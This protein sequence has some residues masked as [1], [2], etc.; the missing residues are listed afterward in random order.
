MQSDRDVGAGAGCSSGTSMGLVSRLL[1][2]GHMAAKLAKAMGAEMIVF[3]STRQKLDEAAR[4][5]WPAA[6][7]YGIDM[8]T[9]KADDRAFSASGRP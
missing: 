8:A 6:L 4:R 2:G 5:V 9:L 3:A 1:A 7:C